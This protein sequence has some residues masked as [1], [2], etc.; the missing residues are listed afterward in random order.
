MPDTERRLWNVILNSPD[1]PFFNFCEPFMYI[2]ILR[3][4]Y[5]HNRASVMC[6]CFSLAAGPSSGD[7]HTF[8]CNGPPHGWRSPVKSQSWK[9]PGEEQ[10]FE[11]GIKNQREKK[12]ALLWGFSCKVWAVEGGT[13]HF[14]S[15]WRHQRAKLNTMNRFLFYFQE[16]SSTVIL[17]LC[18][19]IQSY[20]EGS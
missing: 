19:T 12:A 9:P 1:Q 13:V 20:K 14:L 5:R 8:C 3:H 10:R 4:I 18:R 16:L 17:N 2:R 6:I 7:L 15:W 11:V